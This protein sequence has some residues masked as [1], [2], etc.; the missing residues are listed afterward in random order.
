M[1][2]KNVVIPYEQ[3]AAHA[4]GRAEACN[5]ARKAT[6]AIDYAKLYAQ[7]SMS[8]LVYGKILRKTPP[9]NPAWLF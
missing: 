2:D 1:R 9:N 8:E 3:V 4:R 7:Y 5:G 6:A